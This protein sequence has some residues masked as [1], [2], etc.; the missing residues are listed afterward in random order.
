MGALEPGVALVAASFHESL[1]TQIAVEP[2]DPA[3]LAGWLEAHRPVV[4]A[5]AAALTTLLPGAVA[6]SASGSEFVAR[7][8]RLPEVAGAPLFIRFY[9]SPA[10]SGLT[11]PGWPDG[12]IVGIERDPNGTLEPPTAH[13][14]EDA[15][16]L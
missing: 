11:L 12:L 6:K 1:T 15:G 14:F 13:A 3:T 9:A 2:P 8:L 4:H 7:R 16:F 5:V 10:G